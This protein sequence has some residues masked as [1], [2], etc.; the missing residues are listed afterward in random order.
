MST[1][2]TAII[3]IPHDVDFADL[4]LARDPAT[5][6]VEFDW[7]PIERICKASGLDVSLLRDQHED[8]LAGLL[9]TWHSQHIAAGGQPDPTMQELIAEA[10]AE[11]AHGHGYSHQPGRA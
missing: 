7:A 8:N 11:N 10:M 5:G 4:K 2:I 1:T 6:N 9:N 3:Q